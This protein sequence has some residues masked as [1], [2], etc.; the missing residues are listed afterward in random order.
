M[1]LTVRISDEIGEEIKMIKPDDMSFSKAAETILRLAVKALYADGNDSGDN[2]SS[3]NSN[4]SF[5]ERLKR[6]SEFILSKMDE[7][8]YQNDIAKDEQKDFGN[9]KD[10]NSKIHIQKLENEIQDFKNS[11]EH[12]LK[13]ENGLSEI[14]KMILENQ[15][16][17]LE[18]LK[19]RDDDFPGADVDYTTLV[20]AQKEE[21]Y[22][23]SADTKKY[24]LILSKN[25]PPRTSIEY[26]LIL[27]DDITPWRWMKWRIKDDCKTATLEFTSN[28]M[29]VADFLH[30]K[31]MIVNP[32]EMQVWYP[33][34]SD[35]LERLMLIC[36]RR[37]LKTFRGELPLWLQ[38]GIQRTH[39][40]NYNERL[41]AEQKRINAERKKRGL[42]EFE[43]FRF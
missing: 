17:V 34:K 9:L 8:D 23:I 19:S 39:D 13:I 2:A 7:E 29:A 37:V 31:I 21:Y 16:V 3:D 30:Q 12:F 32:L 6:I 28:I 22:V 18:N 4:E 27:R 41:Y 20:T 1:S 36:E 33:Q 25:I 10:G 26:P 14:S 5:Q 40:V 24:P 38:N 35:S 42:Y 15:K 11:E 43:C